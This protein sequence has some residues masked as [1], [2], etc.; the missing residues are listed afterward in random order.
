MAAGVACSF[1][2]LLGMG[3]SG[4][5]VLDGDGMGYFCQDNKSRRKDGK[6]VKRETK[7]GKRDQ[8]EVA[9]RVQ[10]VPRSTCVEGVERGACLALRC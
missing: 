3:G 5:P 1:H 8:E 9:K 4:L 2:F 10:E 7:K 6:I